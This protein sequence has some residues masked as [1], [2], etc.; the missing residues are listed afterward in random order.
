MEKAFHKFVVQRPDVVFEPAN[1]LA[2]VLPFIGDGATAGIL[3]QIVH[4]KAPFA[5]E[6]PV[7]VRHFRVHRPSVRHQKFHS[8]FVENE[9]DAELRPVEI[10]VGVVA[11][12]G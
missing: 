7:T 9:G 8:L 6:I 3:A 10:R 5:T 1:E 4:R 2:F 11:L 12:T